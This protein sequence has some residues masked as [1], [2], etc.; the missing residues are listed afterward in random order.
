MSE[1]INPEKKTRIKERRISVEVSPIDK[2]PQNARRLARKLALKAL[3]SFAI[4]SEQD[5]EEICQFLW[6]EKKSDSSSEFAKVLVRGA[7][8]KLDIIDPI[9]EKYL[10]NWTMDRVSPVN[11]SILRLSIFSLM[12][13]KDIPTQVVINEAIDLAKIYSEKDDYKFINGLLDKVSKNEAS[14]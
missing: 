4:N 1:E 2:N 5:I 8:E 14:Q 10:Q 11:K 7:I 3:Y 6:E 9:I 12:H 13:L